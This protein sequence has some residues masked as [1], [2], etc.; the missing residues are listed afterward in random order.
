MPD[1]AFTLW[2][3]V[4]DNPDPPT[5]DGKPG[6]V[7]LELTVNATSLRLARLRVQHALQ[8]LVDQDPP[9]DG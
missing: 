5:A 3:Q 9:S 4:T 2:A 8:R 1:Y 7:D 6:R